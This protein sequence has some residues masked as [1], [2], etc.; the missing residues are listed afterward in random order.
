MRS[1]WALTVTIEID[2]RHLCVNGRSREAGRTVVG[3]FVDVRACRNSARTVLTPCLPVA[4][5]TE[6][7]P[8][9]VKEELMGFGRLQ[10]EVKNLSFS[11]WIPRTKICKP[12]NPRSHCPGGGE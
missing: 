10:M 2:K 5:R 9:V 11:Y 7:I 6:P 3:R 4:G 8:I 12:V 1:E